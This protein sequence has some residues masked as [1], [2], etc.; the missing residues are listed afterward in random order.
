MMLC[1]LCCRV[2]CILMWL[3][4]KKDTPS[5]FKGVVKISSSSLLFPSRHNSKN[6]YYWSILLLQQYT[7]VNSQQKYKYGYVLFYF[8]TLHSCFTFGPEFDPL[9]YHLCLKQTPKE[10]DCHLEM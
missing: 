8:M 1:L 3:K 7:S 2:S 4:S 5:T 6:N 9:L 10:F